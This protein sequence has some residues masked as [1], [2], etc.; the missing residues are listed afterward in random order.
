MDELTVCTANAYPIYF[1]SSYDDL[2]E[3]FWNRGLEAT[4]RCI[5]TDSNVAPLYLDKVQNILRG[6]EPFIFEAGEA[7]KHMGTLAD[8]YSHFLA[9]KLDRRKSVIVALGGGVTGDLA[10]FAAATYMRGIRYVQLPTSLLAQVDSSVGGKTAIDFE[11]VK[12]LVGAFYQPEFV[13]I[14]TDTLHTLPQQEFISGLGEVVKH[15]LIASPDY[16]RYV[17]KNRNAILALEKSALMEIVAGSC[18]IKANVVESDERESGPREVLNFG[19]CVGHAIESLSGYSLPHGHCVA[20]GM[21]AALFWSQKLGHIT[22]AERAEALDL[23][24]ALGLPTTVSDTEY[25]LEEI[26]SFMQ[27]DKK[28]QSDALRLVRLKG[29][30]QAYTDNTIPHEVVLEAVASIYQKKP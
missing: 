14:N 5:V 1:R 29:V 23:L 8:M 26:L 16:Y 6:V 13:Y 28:N 27:K 21:S 20:I 22:E 30:G 17:S 9:N 18:R 19:H 25:T 11:G 7:R 2:Q 15:G 24:T 3:A 10:G 12:N 4:K